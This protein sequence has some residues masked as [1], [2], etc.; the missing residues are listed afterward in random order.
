MKI[1]S[2]AGR[3]K[4]APPACE[5][6]SPTLYKSCVASSPRLASPT[7][8]KLTFTKRPKYFIYFYL[9]LNSNSLNIHTFNWNR[10]DEIVFV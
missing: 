5:A 10:L 6:M 3:I 1:G 2:G 8:S 4:Y 9:L 7:L